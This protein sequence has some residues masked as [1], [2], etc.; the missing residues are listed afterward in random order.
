[1]RDLD[2]LVLDQIVKI[3]EIQS[4]WQQEHHQENPELRLE[5]I[6]SEGLPVVI[7]QNLDGL[8]LE[9]IDLGELRNIINQRPLLLPN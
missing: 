4:K 8:I 9:N 3:I 2:H 5:E 1:M 6:V 7:D